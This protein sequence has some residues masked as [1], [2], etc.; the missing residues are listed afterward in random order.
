M[1]RKDYYS[2]L[3]I[4]KDASSEEIK[5]A[6]RKLAKQWHPDL[7]Q[8]DGPGAVKYAEEKFKEI[9]EAYDI[10]SDS[11]KKSRYDAGESGSERTGYSGDYG[12]GGAP[13]GHGPEGGS[14]DP[15]SRYGYTYRTYNISPL[16]NMART[17]LGV[18][19]FFWVC[20]FIFNPS[21]IARNRNAYAPLTGSAAGLAVKDGKFN[22]AGNWLAAYTYNDSKKYF[23]VELRSSGNIFEGKGIMDPFDAKEGHKKIMVYDGVID[24]VTVSFTTKQDALMQQKPEDAAEVNYR[25]IIDADGNISGTWECPDRKS[26]IFSFTDPYKGK[27]ILQKVTENIK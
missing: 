25:G 26:D 4:S 16:F 15:F 8:Q 18:V 14:N 5:N 20:S 2:I 12:T 10:L 17:I 1:D 11:D 9:G 7:H 3:G 22:I 24:G 13:Y 23:Y 21:C 19:I 27:F 6:Y